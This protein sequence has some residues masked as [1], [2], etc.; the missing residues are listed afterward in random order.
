M[1]F[2]IG[3]GALL[4]FIQQPTSTLA[5]HSSYQLGTTIRVNEGDT[6]A[7][8]MLA[9][10]QFV[11]ISGYLADDLFSAS[12]SIA[13]RGS[14]VDDAIIGARSINLSG[15][16]GD[17]LVAAGETVIIDGIVS[18]DLF[19]AGNEIF[20]GPNARIMGNVA[21][22]GNDITIDGAHIDGWLRL[23]GNKVMLNG[24]VGNNVELY[25]SNVTFGEKY[26]PASVT[27]IITSHNL[28]RQDLPNAP[29]NLIITVENIEGAWIPAVLF[30]IWFYI[31]LL[32]IGILLILLFPQTTV[33]LYR[34]AT[35][36]YLRNTGL[37]LLLFVGIPIAI[38]VL[39]ILIFTIPLSIIIGMLYGL[40]L[41]ISFLLVALVLGTHGI[42]FVK[43]N[44]AYNDYYW[45]LSLG[46]II[47]GLLSA[48]P[49]AGPVINISL[50]FF[51]LGTLLSYFW[52][53]RFNSI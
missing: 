5:Q 12:R 32:I 44:E 6:I 38:V 16:V 15:R 46:I 3:I 25:T 24:P 48:L 40:A 28:S 30:S 52:Q 21:L 19:A 53:F 50:I 31:A 36:R 18:G 13:I 37:G 7:K 22:G 1:K 9:G 47:I 45:G 11:E 41:F 2:L 39:L 43:A 10:G 8:N 4:F 42:R 29:D 27:T 23:G 17:M 14:I 33:D 34:Y 35:E 51:G 26:A 20:L 49:Y